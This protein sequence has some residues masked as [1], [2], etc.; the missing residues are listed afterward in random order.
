MTMGSSARQPLSLVSISD[1]CVR[2]SASYWTPTPYICSID[3]PKVLICYAVI[4]THS[5]IKMINF[6]HLEYLKILKH[7][8]IEIIGMNYWDEVTILPINFLVVLQA[9]FFLLSY[10]HVVV[11]HQCDKEWP[12]IQVRNLNEMIKSY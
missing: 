5:S 4:N 12:N 10:L 3:T 1:V 7:I 2:C 8:N 6:H 9:F 11:W